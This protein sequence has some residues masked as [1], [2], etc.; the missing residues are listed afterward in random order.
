MQGRQRIISSPFPSV[1]HQVEDHWSSRK[2]QYAR[3]MPESVTPNQWRRIEELF[4]KA[5]DLPAGD[6][7]AFL[8]TE[9]QG[10]EALRQEVESLL[11]SEG[12]GEILF[13]G[14]VQRLSD[15]LPPEPA[16]ATVEG[17]RV[18][19][20][21][22]IREIGRGGMG[23]VYLASRS[24]DFQKLVAIKLVKRGMDTDELLERFRNERQILANLEHPNIVRL[25][26]GGASEDGA[27]YIVMEYVEGL[28]LMQYCSDRDAGMEERLRLFLQV[29]EGVQ[30][31]HH[32]LTAHRDLKPANILVTA[33]GVVK[34]LD[35]GIAKL[36]D[37]QPMRTAQMGTRLFTPEYASPEQVSGQ[38]V[39]TSTDVYSLG[40]VLYELLSGTRPHQFDTLTAAEIERVVCEVDPVAPSVAAKRATSRMAVDTELDNIV[41]MALRKEPDRRYRSVEQMGDDIRRYLDG[42]P[43]IACGDTL[44]YRAAKFVKRN[45]AW[46]AAAAVALLSMVGGTIAVA[47]QAR[48]ASLQAA[49]AERRFAQ[50][51]TLANTI[52]FDHYDKIKNLNGAT[53]A[54]ESLVKTALAY[55]DSLA[56]ESADDPGL[57]MELAAAYER[58]GDVQGLPGAASLGKR[59]EAKISYQKCVDL[60]NRA[61]AAL[62]QEAK[63]LARAATCHGKFGGML[64]DQADQPIAR[65]MMEKRAEFAEKLVALEPDSEPAQN[66]LYSSYNA[67]GSL[68]A[69]AGRL[70]AAL[71]FARKSLAVAERQAAKKPGAGSRSLLA[72]THATMA[73]LKLEQGDL[74]GAREQI[75]KQIAIREKL[76]QQHPTHIPY[77]RDL[78]LAH[79]YMGQVL[80]SPFQISLGDVENG[81]VQCAQS[82]QYAQ[83]MSHADPENLQGRRDLASAYSCTGSILLHRNPAAA[84][85]E[86]K[87]ELEITRSIHDSFPKEIRYEYSLASTYQGLGEACR[88]LKRLA[89]AK[90]HLERA[91]LHHESIA[92]RSKHSLYRQERL[93]ATRALAAALGEMGDREAAREKMRIALDLARQI[94]VDRPTPMAK[95]DLAETLEAMASV[96]ADGEKCRLAKESAGQWDE[97][98]KQ[99][100]LGDLAAK[101]RDMVTKAISCR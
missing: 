60:V 100:P 10:D 8:E 20:Y 92:R 47:Y 42:R 27:P 39:T 48:I 90:E 98:S 65:Q 63:W 73:H 18:G 61:P 34:L 31:A 22:L 62:K 54:R 80:A 13:G 7:A 19:P 75:E 21:R 56:Q 57:L 14:A 26:D 53:K 32:N 76:S 35:F 87:K 52:L 97:L 38:M 79:W 29:C 45:R 37:T 1:R 6:R 49:R 67:L 51:R 66:I 17:T 59:A 36:L 11:A 40:A 89:A 28:P 12:Q 9:S 70:T 77:T 41:L 84:L 43:V 23:S 78:F 25:L 33:A 5:L 58:V 69:N 94:S 72:G 74:T 85:A 101:R 3:K 88:R 24:D 68:E 55:M 83:Q 15:S 30:C 71:D 93:V 95:A 86:F 64:E 99:T 2:I 50:V 4:S 16:E 96:A 44:G 91:F 46:V 82:L 81:T